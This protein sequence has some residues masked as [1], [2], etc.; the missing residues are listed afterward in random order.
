MKKTKGIP[1]PSTIKNI[2]INEERKEPPSL[3][4]QKVILKNKKLFILWI[5]VIL[6]ALRLFF[7][8]TEGIIRNRYGQK[9]I[10]DRPDIAKT[11]NISKTIF[12]CIGMALLTGLAYI[13]IDKIK[14]GEKEDNN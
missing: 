2:K 9:I 6:I 4:F 11:V 10:T 1:Y 13:S 14:K 5:G 8:V 3:A 12:Q 7:P